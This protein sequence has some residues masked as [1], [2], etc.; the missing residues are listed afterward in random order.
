MSNNVSATMSSFA[1]AL[2]VNTRE[3][4][5]QKRGR[6]NKEGLV[7]QQSQFNLVGVTS[8]YFP[9]RVSSLGLGVA[10]MGKWYISV[11]TNV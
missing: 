9:N 2:K 1:R 3:N 6:N 10:K 11:L 8:I 5:C 7:S 4:P